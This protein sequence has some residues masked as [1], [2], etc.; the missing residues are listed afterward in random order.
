MYL[1]DTGAL[2]SNWVQK[3]P[4][5]KLFTS[6]SIIDEVKNRPSIQRI[7]SMIS[8]GK[9]SIES[10]KDHCISAAKDAAKETGDLSVLSPQDIDLLGLAYR[11]SRTGADVVVVSTDMAILNTA[12]QI[13]VGTIDPRGKMTH[14]IRWELKCPACGH[15]SSNTNEVECLVC[16]TRMKRRPALRRKIE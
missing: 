13:G 5:T 12:L 15:T 2:L 8:L 7:E 3:N 4:D 6:A 1:L 10:P 14:K 9:L 11:F 16:G